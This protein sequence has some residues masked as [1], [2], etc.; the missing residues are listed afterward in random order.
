MKMVAPTIADGST[1]QTSTFK[2]RAIPNLGLV[3]KSEML[4]T[5][6]IALPK[7]LQITNFKLLEFSL[8]N[9]SC[10]H[11]DS[12]TSPYQETIKTFLGTAHMAIRFEKSPNQKT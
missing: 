12:E 10:S 4:S 1:L 8:H 2:D 6:A 9:Q 11:I 7:N 3:R 5:R